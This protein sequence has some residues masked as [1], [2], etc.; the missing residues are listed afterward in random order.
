[1][2]VQG[3][4]IISN[5]ADWQASGGKKREDVIGKTDFDTYP[6]ELAEKYWALDKAVIDSGKSII[7]REEP[8][9]DHQGNPVLVLSSKVPLLDGQGKA[10]ASRRRKKFVVN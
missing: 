2:D 1:M 7:N 8:G 6:S 9:L 3:R 4:K 5:M 10:N